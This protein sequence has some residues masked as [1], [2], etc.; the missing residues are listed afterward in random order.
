M[1]KDWWCAGLGHHGNALFGQMLVHGECGVTWRY[2]GEASKS[3][4]SLVGHEFLSEALKNQTV[5]RLIDI[6]RMSKKAMRIDLIFDLHFLAF[7]GRSE[8]FVSHSSFFF[9]SLGHIKNP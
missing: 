5:G 6:S 7:R 2:R 9:L 3:Q 8:Y 4:Q 1:D